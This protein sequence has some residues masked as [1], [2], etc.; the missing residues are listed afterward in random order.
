MDS[1]ITC[2]SVNFCVSGSFPHS[3]TE[4]G[5]AAGVNNI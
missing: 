4:Q 2:M 1:F 5:P 3:Q